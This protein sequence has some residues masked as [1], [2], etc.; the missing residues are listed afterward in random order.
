LKIEEN[1]AEFKRCGAEKNTKH[2]LW[3]WSSC[4]LAWKNLNSKSEEKK[5]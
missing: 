2:R 5:L 3:N 4:Q 1:F